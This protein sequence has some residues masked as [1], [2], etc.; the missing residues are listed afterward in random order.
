MPSARALAEGGT[1]AATMLLIE[2]SATPSPKPCVVSSTH[3]PH[4][5]S[6]VL[7][8]ESGC[9]AAGIAG[10][11][12][13]TAVESTLVLCNTLQRQPGRRLPAAA[14]AAAQRAAAAQL[15]TCATH[16]THPG[17]KHSRQGQASHP[18]RLRQCSRQQQGGSAEPRNTCGGTQRC[19]CQ[20]P[21]SCCSLTHEPVTVCRPNLHHC[22]HGV[23]ERC[24]QNMQGARAAKPPASTC[25]CD[26]QLV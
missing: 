13:Q 21:L 26:V 12:T 20:Y 19:V 8:G 18:H 7:D 22:S 15:G 25:R 5:S 14:A 10:C 9:S 17:Q 6:H 16:H 23:P 2:G 4:I 24:T 3:Q 11:C 1:C